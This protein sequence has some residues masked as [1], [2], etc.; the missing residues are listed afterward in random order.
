MN[1][2]IIIILLLPLQINRVYSQIGIGTEAPHLSSELD[3]N[4]ESK[5][6]IVPQMTTGQK[7]IITTPAPGLMVYDLD[8][9]CLSMNHGDETTPVWVCMIQDATR[10]FYMPSINIPTPAVG[11][12][13]TPLD[14]YSEYVKQFNTPLAKSISA[15]TSIPYYTSATDLEYYITYYDKN[16][17]DIIDIDNT[18][19][20]TYNIIRKSD[21]DTYINIVFV[22]K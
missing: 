11:S 13:G 6:V 5:G 21:Y 2:L 8:K 18:G 15:P 1:K 12:V 4:S 16:V 7:E 14:L 9:K 3:I 19:K 20:V 22:V 10:F 17:L